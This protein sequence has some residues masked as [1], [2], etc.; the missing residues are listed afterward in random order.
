VQRREH[1]AAVVDHCGQVH[2]LGEDAVHRLLDHRRP[3]VPRAVDVEHG[4]QDHADAVVDRVRG[5]QHLQVAESLGGE[6]RHDRKHQQHDVAE[7]VDEREVQDRLSG[8]DVLDP[9]DELAFDLVDQAGRLEPDVLRGQQAVLQQ[10]LV[11]QQHCSE[12]SEIRQY[13]AQAASPLFA[14]PDRR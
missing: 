1:V 7:H 5:Q 8:E 10:P 3:H 9:G 12:P 13:L 2:H 11:D 14:V 4:V 6:V